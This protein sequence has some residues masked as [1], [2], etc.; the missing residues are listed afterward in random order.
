M[1]TV[2][3]MRPRKQCAPS[4]IIITTMTKKIRTIDATITKSGHVLGVE[5][6]G[7][8]PRIIIPT[9]KGNVGRQMNTIILTIL[10]VDTQ[11]RGGRR[12]LRQH[13]VVE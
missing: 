8:C 9:N 11:H 13:E 10:A 12:R 2:H 3:P 1:V 7:A 4:S 5:T 6:K